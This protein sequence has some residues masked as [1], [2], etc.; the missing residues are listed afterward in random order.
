MATN[1]NEHEPKFVRQMTLADFDR[2]FPDENACDAYLTHQRWPDGVVKCPRCGNPKPYKLNFKKWH[3]QCRL[4]A[5]NGYRFSTITATIFENT[6]VPLLVWFK[7]LY[8]MMTS[9]KGISALQIYRMF[10]MGSYRTAWYMCHRLRASLQE[11]EF[12]Q[13]MGI[14]EVDEAYIG[15]KDKNRHWDKKSH[16]TGGEASGK[17]P[18]I[19]AISRKGNIICKMILNTKRETLDG[20]IHQT[21]S[22]NVTLL[23]TDEHP[24]YGKLS[25]LYPHQIVRHREGEYVRGA[26][27]TN[28]VENFWSLLKRGVMG[29][30]HNV[31]KKYLPLY[32]N[33]FTFRFNNRKNPDIFG[34]AVAGC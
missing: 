30:Y 14:V 19:G 16:K 2:M 18:V 28:S 7:V 12:R 23:T 11:P 21:V 15:G 27:H 31:S 13:L 20:F 1:Q 10:G 29:T 4:C 9:K 34:S 17:T 3:W 25:K 26:V 32:L 5:K 6:N 8:L 24:A 22:P 33:E